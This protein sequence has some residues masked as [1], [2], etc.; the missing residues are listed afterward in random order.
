MAR[1][2]PATSIVMALCLNNRGRRDKPG[3][4]AFFCVLIQNDQKPL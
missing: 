4:D 3:D 2:A 1:L